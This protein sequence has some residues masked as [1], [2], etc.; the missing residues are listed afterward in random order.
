MRLVDQELAR[1]LERAEGMI[2]ASFAD[3][4]NAHT[5]IGA[6]WREVDGTI[7]IF[8]G[9]DSP[10]TQSFGLGTSG[11]VTAAMLDELEAFFGA[12]GADAMHEVSP[13][14]GVATLDLL[15]AR[16]YRPIETS[17]VLVFDLAD[18][19]PAPPPAAALHTRV[20]DRAVDGAAW[21]ETSVGGWSSDPAVAGFVRALAEVNL[22][23]R[24]MSHHVVERAGI[25]IATASLGVHDAVALLAGASTLPAARG[26]GAQAALL[27]ARLT[28]ARARQCHVAMMAADVGST[29]QRNAERRGFRVAYTRTKWRRARGG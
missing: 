23:N 3:A 5:P 1:R 11:A 16:G 20:I 13:F 15:I 19:L 25:A 18:A 26:H 22:A 17:N 14:A 6:T 28:E 21:V 12:R 10:L 9:A 7:A 2:G 29:S 27:A 8:D 24:A 4:R